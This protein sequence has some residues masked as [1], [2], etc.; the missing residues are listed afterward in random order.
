MQFPNLAEFIPFKNRTSWVNLLTNMANAQDDSMLIAAADDYQ[1][2]SADTMDIEYLELLLKH[3]LIYFLCFD[4]YFFTV[5]M[6]SV[7]FP[8]CDRIYVCFDRDCITFLSI[9][10]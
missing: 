7:S 10:K 9:K 1:A 5:I 6:C 3:V 8:C 2:L 4:L